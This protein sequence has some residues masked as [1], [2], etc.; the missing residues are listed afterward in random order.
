[1]A[2]LSRAEIANHA[3]AAG[4]SGEDVNIAVAVALAESGGD[5]RSHNPIPPDDSYGLWQ[6]NMLGPMGP[7]RRHQFGLKSNEDLYDPAT[8]ARVAYGIWKSQGWVRGWTTYKSGKYKKFMGNDASGTTGS[9][10][11]GGDQPDSGV[12]TDLSI[13]ESISSVGNSVFKGFANVAG[14]LVA[15]TFLVIGLLIL[16]RN[17]VGNIIPGGKLLKGVGK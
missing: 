11:T 1:M 5:P 10:G 4:F 17:Q 6:I 2:T 7:S 12:D 3:R 8:N 15:I 14:I 16:A 9:S 13:A